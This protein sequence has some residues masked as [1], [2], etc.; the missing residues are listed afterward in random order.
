MS[1]L[2]NVGSS[3]LAAGP[4]S[5][6]T[7]AI[8]RPFFSFFGREFRVFA[9]NGAQVLYAK[10]SFSWKD[11]WMIYADDTQKVPL[12][13]VAAREAIAVNITTD[14]FDAAS[15]QKVGTIRS[16]GLKSILRDTWEILDGNDQPVGM[17]QEDSMAMMRRML[18]FIMGKWHAEIGGTTTARITQQFRFFTKEFSLDVSPSQGRMDPRFAVACA[19]LALMKELQREKN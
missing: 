10:H 4:F 14:V 15:G 16:K 13:R 18:P 3:E 19:F 6:T 8:K 9:P 1:N 12:L 7:Y 11:Q 17:M 2:A 5:H